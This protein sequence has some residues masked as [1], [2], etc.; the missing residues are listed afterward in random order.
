[1][2]RPSYSAISPS[3]QTSSVVGSEPTSDANS[4]PRRSAS[5]RNGRSVSFAASACTLT[6]N[7]TNSLARAS[8]TISAIVSPALSC[9]SLVLAPRCGVTTISSSSKSGEEVVGSASNT[10]SAAPAIRPSRTTSASSDSTTMPP[11]ATLITRSD[12][13]AFT[14]RSRPI[15]PTVSLFFG[16]C[17]VRKSASATS[18]S[19]GNSSTFICRARSALMK[20]S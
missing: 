20:G 10:S 18:W 6:A 4:R 15:R 13:L 7:G 8:C 2:I 12:G 17:T 3:A 5:G 1:M 16:R 19:S 14:S 11:R 9:A